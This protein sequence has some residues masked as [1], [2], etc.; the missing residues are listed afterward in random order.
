MLPVCLAVALFI[1]LF[2]ISG[3]RGPNFSSTTQ[4]AMATQALVE[5]LNGMSEDKTVLADPGKISAMVSQMG[6]PPYLVRGKRP[7]HFSLQV[8][9]DCQKPVLEAPGIQ[10]G[11]VLYCLAPGDKWA[12]VTVVGLPAEQTFGEPAV[13]SLGGA[14][15]W[16]VVEAKDPDEP[17]LADA[18]T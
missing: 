2:L 5:S 10:V 1:D 16:W 4:L 17:L 12:W 14:E 7:E 18:G 15:Q 13:F 11:T 3:S 6:E 8:R 9:K